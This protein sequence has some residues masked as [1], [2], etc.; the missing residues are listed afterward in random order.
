MPKI[1]DSIDLHKLDKNISLYAYWVLDHLTTDTKDRFSSNEIASHLIEVQKIATS[2]QAIDY[3]LNRSR[4]ACHKT[5]AGFKLMKK[6]RD[7]LELTIDQQKKQT[8]LINANNPFVG[9]YQTIKQILG[10]TYQS[11]AICDP[12]LDFNTLDV[13]HRNIKKNIP[14]RFLTV[15]IIDKPSGSIKRQLNDLIAESYNIEVRKYLSSKLHDRYIITDSCIWLSGNSLNYLGK[16][17]S[18]F[19]LLGTDFH[20]SMLATFNNRWKSAQNI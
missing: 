1:S 8:Y 18:F 3:A 9:K 17:E 13:I 10:E 7:C 15:D 4:G 11:I 12:Y 5:K 14:I 2:R 20:Q 6:G 16:K 19:V